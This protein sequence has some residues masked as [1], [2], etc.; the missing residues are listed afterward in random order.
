MAHL[1]SEIHVSQDLHTKANR[2]EIFGAVRGKI[3]KM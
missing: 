3:L 2:P 1:V